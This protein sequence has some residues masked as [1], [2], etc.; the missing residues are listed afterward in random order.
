MLKSERSTS[1]APASPV[2]SAD[3][4]IFWGCFIAIITTAI[5]FS[6]R[7]VLASDT[8]YWPTQ[9][10]INP[11]KAG[12]LFGAGIWPF[13]ISIIL[14]SFFI[15]QVGYKAAMF[16]SAVCYVLYAVMALRAYGIVSAPGLQGDALVGAQ[17]QAYQSLYWGSIILGLGNGTVEAFANPVVATIFNRQKAKWLNRLHAGW[18]AGLVLGGVFTI[19]LHEQVQKDWRIVVFLLAIPAI[20]Y[21]IM[22]APAKFPIQERVASGTTYKEMLAE[23]GVIGAAIAG[24]LVFKQLGDALH[25]NA[26]LTYGLL[27]VSLI[28]YGVYSRSLGRPLMIALCLIM[29]PLATTE[30]GTDSAVTGLMQTPMEAQGLNSA[31]VLVYTSAIMMVL[32]FAA[33]PLIEKF[34]PIGVLAGG[35]TL[36]ILGLTFLGHAGSNLGIIFVAAT[37]YGC[38]KSYFWPTSLAIASERFPR[39]GALTLNALGGIGMLA[40]GIIG[41]PLIGRMQEA[42][43]QK[44]LEG[45]SSALY[46]QISK[47]DKY[48]L[49]DYTSVDSDKVKGLPNAAEITQTV[50]DAKQAALANMAIFPLVMLL[51]YIGLLAY[52]KTQG[53]YKAVHLSGEEMA[54]GIE[55]AAE[56]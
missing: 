52:F 41:G 42:S 9:F 3:L 11:V 47:P 43:A 19:L 36:A 5:A 16:F 13:A 29:I 21:L 27:I 53:G 17:T 25:W 44:A 31:W 55:G 50:G 30:L 45:Q 34:S 48:I 23:F 10:N 46:T 22:L 26:A 32:R 1:S 8:H 40:V 18:P 24:W 37:L 38:G 2:S 49:G 51:A 12:E 33:G 14:F 7:A 4:K 20:I 6:T 35:A 56:A 54:G 39:G 28:V 15:D